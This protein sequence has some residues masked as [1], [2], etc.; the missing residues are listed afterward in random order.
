MKT[1]HCIEEVDKAAI[2]FYC[3]AATDAIWKCGVEIHSR[4]LDI[5]SCKRRASG[6]TV[7]RASV[8]VG[9]RNWRVLGPCCASHDH[10]P[11]PGCYPLFSGVW[12]PQKSR[13]IAVPWQDSHLVV[14][15]RRSQNVDARM[16]RP[17]AAP[18]AGPKRLHFPDPGELPTLHVNSLG[19]S[20]ILATVSGCESSSIA[21]LEQG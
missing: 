14:K 9:C 4:L 16:P 15:G 20:N 12:P 17:E 19:R 5:I 21:R 8:K 3:T 18:P 6:R 7:E 1:G 10:C 11:C 13:A 2:S